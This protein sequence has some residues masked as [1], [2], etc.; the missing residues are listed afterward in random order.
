M[1]DTVE[2]KSKSLAI[3]KFDKKAVTKLLENTKLTIEKIGSNDEDTSLILLA[4]SLFSK[5]ITKSKKKHFKVK[6]QS[7]SMGVRG[8]EFFVSYGKADG[9]EDVWM[10]VDEGVVEVSV[11]DQKTVLV[12]AKEGVFI[13]KGKE[14]SSVKKYSWTKKL[15]WNLNPKKGKLE[16]NAIDGLYQDLLDQDYD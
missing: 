2:V 9:K 3:I 1:G 11:Q 8:T 10:C 16:N 14:I 12:R 6:A 4:G 5:V 7:A 15:N 13:K